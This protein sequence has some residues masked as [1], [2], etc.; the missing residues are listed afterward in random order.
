MIWTPEAIE[1]NLPMCAEEI[2]T[3]LGYKDVNTF[4]RNRHKLSLIEGMPRPISRTGK[5][6]YDRAGMEAWLT[7]HD[8]RRPPAAANDAIAPPAPSSDGE[9]NSFLHQH[10]GAD[11]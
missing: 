11:A 6:A 9:W 10:Y 7:R 3:R 8:P 2:A 5:Q 4:Y 1:R